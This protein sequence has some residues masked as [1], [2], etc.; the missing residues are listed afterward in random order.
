MFLALEIKALE[1]GMLQGIRDDGLE[2]RSTA[3]DAASTAVWLQSQQEVY[4]KL[5]D[6]AQGVLVCLRP[7]GQLSR[8]P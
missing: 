8:Q 2:T 6:T 3:C 5:D 4:I 7:A 1:R